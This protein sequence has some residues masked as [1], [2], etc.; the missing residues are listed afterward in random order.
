MIAKFSRKD[1]KVGDTSVTAQNHPQKQ[2][3]ISELK[4]TL[5]T[6]I[7]VLTAAQRLERAHT[8]KYQ[9]VVN[10]TKLQHVE[11]LLNQ[12][13]KAETESKTIID[14]VLSKIQ[15]IA[16]THKRLLSALFEVVD[17]DDA[18]EAI[19]CAGDIELRIQRVQIGI[20]S[21]VDKLPLQSTSGSG[22]STSNT[23]HQLPKLPDMQLPQFAG[24]LEDWEQFKETFTA[25]IDSRTDLDELNKLRYLK[26][27]CTGEAAQ[28]I[29]DL[30][31]TAINYNEALKI[32]ETNYEKKPLIVRKLISNLV[33]LQAMNK[34]T[35]C[36]IMRIILKTNSIILNL[37]AADQTQNSLSNALIVEIITAKLDDKLREAWEADKPTE[38]VATWDELAAFL[39]K[40]RRI[41]EQLEFHK[42]LLKEPAD[43]K[44]PRRNLR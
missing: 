42:E 36:E 39:E 30:K 26:S 7:M 14:L 37:K 35:A 10:E 22:P 15:E 9:L 44:N 29:G 24:A 16:E 11:T 1:K 31:I 43:D 6:L 13:A 25:L 38:S 27:Y 2:I 41:K 20:C 32:L 4:H 8:L 12:K 5:H 3:E 19:E 40:T 18:A 23:P 28:L 33:N 34:P 21:L 17:E